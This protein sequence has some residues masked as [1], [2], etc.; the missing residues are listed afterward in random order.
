MNIADMMRDPN[1][2]SLSQ[3]EQLFRRCRA[4]DFWDEHHGKPVAWLL[5]DHGINGLQVESVQRLLD[6]M[7][8]AHHVD[9]ILRINGKDERH[10]A[11]WV[12]HLTRA[13][14]GGP[15]R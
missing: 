1:W 10:Q 7:W 14:A 4:A 9:L 12:K 8:A 3:N 5:T 2:D 11:D 6:R 13:K 15:Q